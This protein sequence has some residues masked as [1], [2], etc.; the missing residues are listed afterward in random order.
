MRSGRIVGWGAGEAPR[1]T[2]GGDAAELD[3]GARHSTG[4]WAGDVYRD[5][6]RERGFQ[7]KIS[8]RNHKGVSIDRGPSTEPG[9]G[10]EE[11]AQRKPRR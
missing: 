7:A 4:T 10:E 1:H 8:G 5:L 6:S 3:V 9:H 11:E 2:A